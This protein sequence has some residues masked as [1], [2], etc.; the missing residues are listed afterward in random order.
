MNDRCVA[1]ENR[2]RLDRRWIDEQTTGGPDEVHAS[3]RLDDL[4]RDEMI[5]HAGIGHRR[6]HVIAEPDHGVVG[7]LGALHLLGETLAHW[8]PFTRGGLGNPT[9]PEKPGTSLTIATV[10]RCFFDE[11]Q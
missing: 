9:L 3:H 7:H 2:Q 6:V 11:R 10:A 4:E 5:D 1:D 8:G